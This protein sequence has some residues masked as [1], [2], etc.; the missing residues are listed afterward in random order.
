MALNNQINLVKKY[1][2]EVDSTVTTADAFLKSADALRYASK[3]L[4]LYMDYMRKPTDF[5][6]RVVPACRASALKYGY[7]IISVPVFIPEHISA[8]PTPKKKSRN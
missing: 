2:D 3:E 1:H 8:R 4:S 6:N 7:H 5:I